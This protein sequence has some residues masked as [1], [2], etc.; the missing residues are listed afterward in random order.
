MLFA[1]IEVDKERK[2]G[3]TM[4]RL[5]STRKTVAKDFF[6]PVCGMKVPPSRSIRVTEYQG[7]IYYF[8]AEACK[9]AFEKNPDQYLEC[10]Q[11]KP[12]NW[13]M[14]WLDKLA[15][16]NREEFGGKPTCH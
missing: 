13:F 7:H 4:A 14:R 9:K 11:A 12:K 1:P 6:D 8:C 16:S 3:L 5:A 15:A 2:G 10:Q